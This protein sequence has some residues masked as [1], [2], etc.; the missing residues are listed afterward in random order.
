[1]SVKE[2]L[3]LL[4]ENLK[5]MKELAAGQTSEEGH[6]L[7][8]ARLVQTLGIMSVTST[9]AKLGKICREIYEEYEKIGKWYA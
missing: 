2:A 8:D 1:M 7:A 9:S 6:A 3:P 5:T 4:E